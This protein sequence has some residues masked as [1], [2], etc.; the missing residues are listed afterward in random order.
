[1]SQKA[2]K[3]KA[4]TGSP[5][6]A[7]AVADAKSASSS[8]SAAETPKTKKRTSAHVNKLDKATDLGCAATGAKPAAVGKLK[9][10]SKKSKLAGTPLEFVPQFPSPFMPMANAFSMLPYLMLQQQCSAML[11][12]QTHGY[13]QFMQ[14]LFFDPTQAMASLFSSATSST[15]PGL[16]PPQL[17]HFDLMS[18]AN[19]PDPVKMAPSPEE[20]Q[21]L[22]INSYHT[23]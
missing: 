7:A 15:L 23:Q 22:K 6:D 12:A 18:C 14:P 5:I 13:Q 17:P 19:L 4:K 2:K 8:G 11:Q 10:A 1:M 21:E 3:K 20:K 16:P 9:K